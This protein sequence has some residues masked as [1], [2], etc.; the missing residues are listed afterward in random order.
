MEFFYTCSYAQFRRSL[1]ATRPPTPLMI[2][3]SSCYRRGSLRVRPFP[4]QARPTF[5]DSG[6]F[7]F[8]SRN[9]EY[10]FTCNDYLVW[11]M[12]MNPDYASVMDYPCEEEIAPDA[13]AVRERQLRT[14]T[15]ARLLMGADVPWCWLPVIQGFHRDQYLRHVSDYQEA[16]LVR[17]YMGIGSLCNRTSTQDIVE[18]VEA[19]AEA[20]PGVRFHLFGV[21][22]QIVESKVALPLQ[23]TSADS[24]AWNGR[25]GT[26]INV[27]N[28]EAQQRGWSQAQTEI[29]WALP[30][31]HAKITAALAQQKQNKLI[32]SMRV[33]TKPRDVRDLY[34]E[35]LFHCPGCGTR[36]DL[37]FIDNV[38]CDDDESAEQIIDALERG[39]CPCCMAPGVISNYRG[40]LYDTRR[41]RDDPSLA[42]AA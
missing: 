11:L 17:P 21:K 26:N 19:I 40:D 7:V 23:V 4:R 39:I 20:L 18:I 10:P 42:Y 5:C 12:Q 37:D 9:R 35:S 32:H 8:A 31:Y 3:A 28:A 24:G 41:L 6:G 15:N 33:P 29:G 13:E 27:F 14:I 36:S 25:F 22:L 34:A 16:D 30:R 2:A 38:L 1:W